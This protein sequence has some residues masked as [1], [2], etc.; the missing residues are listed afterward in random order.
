[1]S[2]HRQL[3]HVDLSVTTAAQA[4]L[5]PELQDYRGELS[6]GFSIRNDGTMDV[7]V[8]ASSADDDSAIVIPSG[9]DNVRFIGNYAYPCET[10][11][12]LSVFGTQAIVVSPVLDVSR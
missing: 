7:L 2:H 4:L 12:L 5:V 6:V 1:M 10:P 9:P 8:T 3:A 11:F